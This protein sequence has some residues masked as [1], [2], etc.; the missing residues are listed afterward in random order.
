MPFLLTPILHPQNRA[1]ENYN[2]SHKQTRQCVERAFGITKQRFRC[3]HRSGGDLT[4]E[5]GKACKIIVACMIL[6]NMCVDANLPLGDELQDDSDGNEDGEE[7]NEEGEEDRQQEDNAAAARGGRRDGWTD[8][9][10]LINER[11]I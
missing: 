1:E 2:R 5:P 9:S 10:E 11:F 3:I 4:Y 8:R 6:H 7:E